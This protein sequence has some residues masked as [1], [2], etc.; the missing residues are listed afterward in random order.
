MMNLE[1]LI[2]LEGCVVVSKM[3]FSLQKITSICLFGV[4]C[5]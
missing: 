1:I 4:C 2:L 5:S 3:F